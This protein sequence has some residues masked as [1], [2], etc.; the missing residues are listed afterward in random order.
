MK[1]DTIGQ[2]ANQKV[3]NIFSHQ[4]NANLDYIN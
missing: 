3:M 2:Q 1:E 4:Q